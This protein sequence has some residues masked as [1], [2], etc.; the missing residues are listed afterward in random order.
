M[1][2][3][4]EELDGAVVLLGVE[5][6]ERGQG[7]KRRVVVVVFAKATTSRRSSTVSIRG[8]TAVA[9]CVSYYGGGTGVLAR[10]GP[11]RLV[12]ILIQMWSAVLVMVTVMD[13]R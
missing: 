11:P 1:E 9:R 7:G 6:G 5:G 4:D 10:D 12:G 3:M 2:V 8:R 13:G